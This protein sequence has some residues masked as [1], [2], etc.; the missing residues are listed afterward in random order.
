MLKPSTFLPPNMTIWYNLMVLS[1]S[2]SLMV[3]LDVSGF[4]LGPNDLKLPRVILDH[5]AINCP[6]LV[7]FPFSPVPI[8][9]LLSVPALPL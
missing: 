9:S 2:G 4:L 8:L 7:I 6:E 3:F 1:H 5:C